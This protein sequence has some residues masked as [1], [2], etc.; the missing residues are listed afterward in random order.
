[1][2]FK[3]LILLLC[4]ISLSVN[5][6][7]GRN[8][9]KKSKT[10]KNEIT[11]SIVDEKNIDLFLDLD[12]TTEK[13]LKE[14][15]YFQIKSNEFRVYANYVNPFEFLYRS[16][17]KTLDDELFIASQEFLKNVASYIAGFQKAANRSKR[18]RPILNAPTSDNLE[19]ELV[20]M[21]LIVTSQQSNFFLTNTAFWDTMTKLQLSKANEDISKKYSKAFKKLKNITTISNIN[22]VISSNKTS[23]DGNKLI[24]DN[25]KTR[26]TNLKIEFGKI[27]FVASKLHLKAYIE[28]IITKLESNIKNLENLKTDVDSKYDK[29]KE[30]FSSIYKRKHKLGD[31]KFLI[32]KIDDVKSSK[33]HEITVILEKISFN[34][35]EKSIK[36]ESSKSFI[37]NA[38]KK[39]TFIPVLSSGVLYT[40]LSFP[41]YGTDTNDT[42]ETIITQTEDKENELS[43]AAYLNLYLNNNWDIPV[44]FQ[45]GV[46]PSK[47]KPL[48]F[49]GGGIELA[50]K[51]TISSGAVFTWHPKLNDLSVGDKV[52]GSSIIN[53]DISYNFNLS[54]KF[55]FGISIDITNK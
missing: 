9:I 39:T 53:N 20:E 32:S 25:L 30:L 26:F 40:N 38:R 55:Y 7:F 36:I 51:F 27:T 21:Y 13:T 31:N 11:L 54:P 52:G 10:V 19:P 6:Q 48:F 5:A 45:L 47:E 1:M 16:S 22:K 35:S 12:K 8:E 34:D 14:T 18:S 28:N 4:F 3:N 24:I 41:Q 43:V 23:L 15:D 46:G 49:L 2:K 33:R 50:S 42:G 37:I 44:F 29:I 17:Q